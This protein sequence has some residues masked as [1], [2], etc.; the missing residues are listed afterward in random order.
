M[1]CKSTVATITGAWATA[2]P[3]PSSSLRS[4]L[5]Y[6]LTEGYSRRQR[7]QRNR[8]KRFMLELFCTINHAVVSAW[9]ERNANRLQH[10]SPQDQ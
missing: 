6:W 2:E 4:E 1:R 10:R 8:R 7:G 5:H 9:T 3:P